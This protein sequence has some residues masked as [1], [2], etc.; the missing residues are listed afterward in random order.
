VDNLAGFQVLA[1][2]CHIA[3]GPDAFDTGL[4]IGLNFNETI[5]GKFDAEVG[6]QRNGGGGTDF[7]KN[8]LDLKGVFALEWSVEFSAGDYFVPEDFDDISV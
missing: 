8:P 4:A 6:R 1:S 5:F 7:D 2:S 3:T